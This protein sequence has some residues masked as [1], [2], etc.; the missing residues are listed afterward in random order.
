MLLS[1]KVRLLYDDL[2]VSDFRAG[3]LLASST[4]I[5]AQVRGI[6]NLVQ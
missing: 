6:N 4:L 2:E 3:T 5:A 1:F